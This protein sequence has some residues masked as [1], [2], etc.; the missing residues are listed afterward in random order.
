MGKNIFFIG[1]FFAFFAL[2]YASIYLS[3]SLELILCD[4]GQGDAILI[5]YR[6]H[7]LLIDAGPGEKVTECLQRY[8]PPLDLQIEMIVATHMDADHIGGFPGVI[9]RYKVH[10]IITSNSWK[11]TETSK[12]FSEAI[13]KHKIPVIYPNA[14]EMIQSSPFQLKVIWPVAKNEKK[15]DDPEKNEEG[16]DKGIDSAN[17]NSVA[18][19]LE[20]GGFSALFLGDLEIP[21]EEEMILSGDLDDVDLI[22]IG[23]HGSKNA[24]SRELLENSQA[25]IALIGVG[26]KNRYGHPT[27]R[28]IQLL[29]EFGIKIHRTDLEG[30]I[31]LQ[32]D[33]VHIWKNAEYEL[34]L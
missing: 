11:S 8:M 30:D 33:G 7:Q 10:Q 15:I 20:F 31:V 6:T 23:H 21:Q 1:V 22:K 3:D 2:F 34:S 19:R 28:V 17:A 5:Q 9:D 27:P 24:T 26:K 29:E 18:I 14:G 25:K 13:K 4:V 16:L 12:R 32:T